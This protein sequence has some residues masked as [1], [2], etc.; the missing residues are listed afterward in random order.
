M[1]L[2]QYAPCPCGNGKKLKFCKCVDQ[3]QEYEK[4]V[5]LMDGGQAVA[6]VDRINS[7]LKKTPNAAWLLALKGELA[8][9]MQ[10]IDTFKETAQR[11]V[12]LKP[13]NPLAL[14]MC[15]MAA[16]FDGEPVQQ[17]AR[18]LLD[19]MSEAREALPGMTLAAIQLLISELNHRGQLCL[20]GFWADA[21]QALTGGEEPERSVLRD[22]SVNLLA[23]SPVVLH[24]DPPQV[25]WKERLAEVVSLTKSFRYA[26][27][28]TKLRAILRDY[29]DQPGPLTH[30]LRAQLAQLDQEGAFTTATKLAENIQLP[31]EDRVFYKA[32]SLELQPERPGL[33]V[34]VCFKYCEIDSVE[35]VEQLAASSELIQSGAGD[36]TLEIRKY[37]GTLVGDEVPAK[38][39]FGVLDRPVASSDT[40]GSAEADNG[41][42]A[43]S[44]AT[45]AVFGKQTDKPARVLFMGHEY[46]AYQDT[47]DQLL[48]DLQLGPDQ[49]GLPA[50]DDSTFYLDFLTR[51]RTN[52][53][54]PFDSVM[55]SHPEILVNE[56]L[57]LPISGLGFQSPLQMAGDESQRTALLGFLSHF[58]GEQS[59]VVAPSVL[60]EIYQ[61]LDLER[62]KFKLPAADEPVKI[63]NVLDLDRIAVANA[64]DP[65]LQG[66][67]TRTFSLGAYRA[68]T[69]AAL[70]VRNRDS[71]AQNV[72]L[73]LTTLLGLMTT[74]ENAEERIGY[75]AEL[76][77]LAAAQGQSPGRFVL[78]RVN[79]LAAL[80]RDGEAQTCLTEALRKYPED[81]YLL[82]FVQQVMQS[83]GMG[84][85]GA[86]NPMVPP[87]AGQPGAAP[88]QDS[89]L[90]LPGQESGGQQGES[91]LWLPGS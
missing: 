12:K 85:P 61:K 72:Q 52:P 42:P 84:P 39:V 4:I 1:S 11:F 60:E 49:E 40:D 51:S 14:I 70:E 16:T 91:K 7:L 26:Q 34:K 21:F 66:I 89:G 62:P 32:V 43:S 83:Q 5:K 67:V 90:V 24:D 8:L 76:E 28:E 45:I 78:Q 35:R 57:N 30:L 20:V 58:E 71:L 87:A 80:G 73:N 81:P 56:L 47:I 9:S 74:T 50:Q 54:N 18:H 65:Q 10:E 75:C 25:E 19:G 2:D 36:A 23:K 15:A 63:R 53:S 33:Q 64:S 3:P 46:P 37:Y 77:S 86:A 69:T 29:P 48:D 38:H 27:A 55:Q 17:V 22:P 82:S 31:A 79:M 41:G 13:D 68:F 6:A 59:I 44:L 88:A